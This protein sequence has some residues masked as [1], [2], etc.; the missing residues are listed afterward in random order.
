MKVLVLALLIGSFADRLSTTTAK[1]GGD[2]PPYCDPT[3]KTCP[4]QLT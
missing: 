3:D 1:L 4:T 2:P